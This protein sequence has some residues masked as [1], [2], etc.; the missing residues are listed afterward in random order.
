MEKAKVFA[1][2]LQEVFT[3]HPYE[4]PA[5]YEIKILRNLNTPLLSEVSAIKF[6]RTEVMV[7]VKNLNCKKAPG[8][9]PITGKILKELPEAGINYLTQLYNDILRINFFPPQWKIAQVKMIPKSNK[10]TDNPKSYPC[11]KR[12]IRN[13]RNI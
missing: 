11:L 7:V 10:S 5:E 9:D 8:Y 13:D 1:E 3:S 6:T 12:T 2:H 4:G